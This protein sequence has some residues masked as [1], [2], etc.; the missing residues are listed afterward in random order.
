MSRWTV[1]GLII[2]AFIVAIGAALVWRLKIDP[3]R[4]TL[5]VTIVMC[6]VTAV[7]A[8]LT[9]GILLQ[10]RAMAQ[11]A[12]DST[13]VMERSLRFSYSPNLLYMTLST[14]DPRFQAR[15]GFAPLDNEDL[16]RALREYTEGQQQTEFVF[17]VVHNVG[18]GSATNLNMDVQYSVWDTSSPN[19]SYSVAKQATVPILES[20]NAVALYIYVSK[21]PTGDDR[22]EMT[23]ATLTASDFYRDALGEPPQKITIDRRHHH[24]ESEPSCVIRLR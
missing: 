17:A 14:K 5:V 11:A 20:G 2:V 8:L 3:S 7:Y 15:E 23:S 22:V 21:V 4:A 10:N 9:F 6:G 24:T 18:R 12:T 1:V 19:A 13:R 16:K